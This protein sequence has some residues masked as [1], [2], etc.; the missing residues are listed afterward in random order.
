MR[1]FLFLILLLIFSSCCDTYIEVTYEYEGVKI[2]RVDECGV[3]TFYYGEI[4]DTSPRVW[5]TYSGINDGF[6]GYLVF[7]ENQKVMILSGDGY[8]QSANVDTSKLEYSRISY[9]DITLGKRG[10]YIMLA[11]KVEKERNLVIGSEIK[12]EYKD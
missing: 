9:E 4:S 5:A 8:F 3:S 7:N 12:V 10:Y 6:S 11:T 1:I 2:K